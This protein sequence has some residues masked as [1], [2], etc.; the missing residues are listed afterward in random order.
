[1]GIL[2]D[3]KSWLVGKPEQEQSQPERL[4]APVQEPQ[5]PTRPGPTP[6]PAPEPRPF[7]RMVEENFRDVRDTINAPTATEPEV[8]QPEVEA[9]ESGRFGENNLQTPM[10]PKE[11]PGQWVLS[12]PGPGGSRSVVFVPATEQPAH[13]SSPDRSDT[14]ERPPLAS[15]EDVHGGDV[16]DP[17]GMDR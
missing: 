2:D 9:A 12:P 16:N 1:M 15:F 10:E 17:T 3:I 7:D 13:D 8:T 4:E 5:M 6:E 11:Q 14:A